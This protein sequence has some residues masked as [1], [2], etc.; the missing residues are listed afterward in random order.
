M[1]ESSARW[2]GIHVK[3]VKSTYNLYLDILTHVFD[4]SITKGGGGGG[5]FQGILTSPKLLYFL[6]HKIVCCLII[7]GLFPFYLCSERS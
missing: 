3:I 7:I 6:N 5:G 2:D 4:I 1:K